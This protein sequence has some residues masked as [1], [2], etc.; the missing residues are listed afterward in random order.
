MLRFRT[1]CGLFSMAVLLATGA[2]GTTDAVR[3]TAGEPATSTSTT[4]PRVVSE[5]AWTPFA[6][7]GPVTL[8]HPSSRV[9]RVAF[10][11]SGHDG[12]RQLAALPGAVA[13]TTLEDRKRDTGPHGAVDVVVDPATE[14]RS[15]VTGRVKRAGRYVLYLSLIHI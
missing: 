2:C 5:T 13:P 7:S 12:A 4:P 14:I 1:T 3:A 10:H 9:E 8:T 15:P 11:Q 6:A